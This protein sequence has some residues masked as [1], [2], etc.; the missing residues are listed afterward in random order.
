MLLTET[1]KH[2][3]RP[4]T[5]KEPEVVAVVRQSEWARKCY[6]LEDISP[7][8]SLSKDSTKTST[9]R[10]FLAKLLSGDLF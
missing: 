8:K 5:R 1:A 7:F 2:L 4:F 3:I 10:E 6:N 9:G